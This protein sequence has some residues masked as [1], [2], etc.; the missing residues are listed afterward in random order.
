ML[1]IVGLGRCDNFRL[2]SA[3]NKT[4]GCLD[5]SQINTRRVSLLL[6][7]LAPVQSRI[8]L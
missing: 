3:L 1:G 7:Q 5:L 4:G 2:T 6:H 8:A